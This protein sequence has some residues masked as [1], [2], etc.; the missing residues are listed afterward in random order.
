MSKELDRQRV[1]VLVEAALSD[2]L[3]EFAPTVQATD[4][5]TPLIGTGGVLDSLGLI[6]LVSDIEQRLLAEYDRDV[7]VADERAM[8]KQHS[9]FLTVETLVDYVMTLL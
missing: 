8:S 2:V 9:P 1:L 4:E 3:R 7:I 6:T 5:S